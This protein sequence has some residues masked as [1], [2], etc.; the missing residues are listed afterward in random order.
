MLLPN[1]RLSRLKSRCVVTRAHGQC[2][3]SK[4]PSSVRH[5]SNSSYVLASPVSAPAADQ[6]SNTTG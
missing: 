4:S 3:A 1:V 6:P 5:A 2:P